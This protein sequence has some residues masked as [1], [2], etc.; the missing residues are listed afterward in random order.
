MK[1]GTPLRAF[2]PSR[3]IRIS[4]KRESL[5]VDTKMAA[6]WASTTS[7]RTYRSKSCTTRRT[8]GLLCC[9]KHFAI[10]GSA[11][12]PTCSGVIDITKN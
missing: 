6:L 5:S 12:T 8:L 3:S 7:W 9:R 10:D 1:S 11:L 4:T 2:R